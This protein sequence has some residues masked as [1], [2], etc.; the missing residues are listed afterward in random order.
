[1]ASK[2]EILDILQK[3]ECLFG[4]K[5]ERDRWIIKTWSEKDRDI[6]EFRRE[7]NKVLVYILNEQER[8]KNS[9]L[10]KHVH[11]VTLHLEDGREI[12]L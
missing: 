3:W 10:F 2:N 8:E 12:D 11:R 5:S 6:E 4:S 9:C 7:L 1:M